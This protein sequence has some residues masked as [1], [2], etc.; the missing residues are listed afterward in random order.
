MTSAELTQRLKAQAALLGF[1]RV[2][3]APALSP[4][5]HGHFLAW[6]QAGHAAGM[7]Y[8]RRHAQARSHPEHVLAGVRSVVM[9]SVVYRSARE[10]SSTPRAGSG[11]VARYARGLDYH[12]VLKDK[13]GALLDW[14]RTE[15]PQTRGRA[16]TDTAPL[17]ERDFAR[18]AGL[19][20][21][22]K[23]TMLIDPKLGSFTFLGALLV[24]C[25][26]SPDVPF[27]ANHCGTCTRC[28]NACPTRAFVGPYQLDA[29]RCISYWTIEHK[30]SIAASVA[31]SLD[32]WVFGCDICQDVCPWNRKA[33][34][35]HLA[36]F[37]DRSEG[38]EPDLIEWLDRDAAA[39]HA[40]LQDSALERTGRVGL[41]R[42]AALVLGQQ[43]LES[44][45]PALGRR[46][47]DLNEDPV[48]RAAS[49]WALG[50]IGSDHAR[51]HLLE[52][53]GSDDPTVRDAVA[54]ALASIK[55][56]RSAGQP[57]GD[58]P[59]H[60]ACPGERF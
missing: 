40:A 39:W 42:T 45:V 46:L 28:L 21:I 53:Q 17:L 34:P 9:A 12:G 31:E 32:G 27:Q 23:N 13:L 20:W 49:A 57:G 33:P 11:K 54:S 1:D 50:Q 10:G 24:D 29:R 15:R 48:I 55:S 22:G 43:R 38:A 60:P 5:G 37:Q 2:G 58:E 14:L 47:A 18:L 4:P 25:E 16:V 19:G 51:Q 26:L 52:N 35:G 41:V 59:D 3:I 56:K 7:E 36:E 8:M 30:G 44:S 6:L